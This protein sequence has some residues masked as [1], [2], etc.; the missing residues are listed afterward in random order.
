M[1]GGHQLCADR[2][3]V[4]TWFDSNLSHYMQGYPSGDGAVLIK[5]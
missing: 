5:Q 3:G 2:N 4:E 1:S